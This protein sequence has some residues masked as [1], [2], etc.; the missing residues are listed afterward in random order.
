MEKARE[1][2]DLSVICEMLK[3][4]MVEKYSG[5]KAYLYLASRH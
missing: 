4:K 5:R 2:A 1:L 3:I